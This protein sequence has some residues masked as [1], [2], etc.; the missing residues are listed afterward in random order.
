MSKKLYIII[1]IIL[2]PNIIDKK[3]IISTLLPN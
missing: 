2:L 1:I 3:E